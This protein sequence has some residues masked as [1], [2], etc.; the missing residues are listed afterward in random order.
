[1]LKSIS[2]E[3]VADH[4]QK[5]KMQHLGDEAWSLVYT[6]KLFFILVIYKGEF[7]QD[8]LYTQYILSFAFRLSYK[9]LYEI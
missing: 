3:V 6:H 2:N 5:L 1:M 7:L 8:Y 9:S 4:Q